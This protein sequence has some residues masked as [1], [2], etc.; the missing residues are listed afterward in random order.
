MISSLPR[1]FLGFSVSII[2]GHITAWVLV[3]KVLY[4][5]A[6]KKNGFDFP[7][8]RSHLS[9]AVGIVE[10]SICTGALFLAGVHGWQVIAGWLALKVAA[11]WQKAKNDIVVR[12]S[13]NIWLIGTALSVAFGVLGAWLINGK[14]PA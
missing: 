11:R 6:A 2:G 7:A 3:E 12:D 10:R 5:Y 13:D 4:P 14:L 1:V 8:I 9:G